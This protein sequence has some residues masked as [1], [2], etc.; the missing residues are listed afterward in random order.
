MKM[1]APV[2]Q[3]SLLEELRR[4]STCAIANAI[5][6]LD[7]RLRNAGFG[8]CTIQCRF[9]DFE[10]V[11]GYAVT[12]RLHGANPPMEGGI[13]ADSTDWWDDLVEGPEPH[14]VIIED[15][16]RRMGTAAFVGE[17]HAAILKALGAVAVVTNGAV[18]DLPEVERLG[19]QLF[20][21]NVSVSHAYAHVSQVDSTVEVA[22]LKIRPGELLHGDRHGIVKVPADRIE[23]VIEIANGLRAREKEILRFC[24]ST[25]FSR[26]GLRSLLRRGT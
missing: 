25:E 8:D 6:Y 22:G 3:P 1:P 19:F 20:S 11:A 16:D 23:Q 5:E 21:G 15:A 14:I 4:F 18:R 13:Y 12:L 7:M 10:P 24:Q 26:D 17:T 9:P 2:V